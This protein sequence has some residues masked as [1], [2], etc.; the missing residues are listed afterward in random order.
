MYVYMCIYIYIHT[1]T[2]LASGLRSASAICPKHFPQ[3]RT[4]SPKAQP[5]NSGDKGQY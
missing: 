3:L 4:K 2:Y 5:V 1:H